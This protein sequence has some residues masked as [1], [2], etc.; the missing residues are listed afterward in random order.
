VRRPVQ[1]RK[2]AQVTGGRR[3]GGRDMSRAGRT[4]ARGGNLRIGAWALSAARGDLPPGPSLSPAWAGGPPGNRGA[5]GRRR[6]AGTKRATPE[7]EAATTDARDAWRPG[8]RPSRPEGDRDH[9]RPGLTRP[10]VLARRILSQPAG[11][12]PLLRGHRARALPRF[13]RPGTRARR[14]PC[15]RGSRG[16][17]PRAHQGLQARGGSAS[18]ASV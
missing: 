17:S 2:R 4:V 6:A 10:R 15:Q 8:R 3:S 9:P 13:P 7:P 1:E 12:V 11:V 16:G 14:R 5:V 18:A